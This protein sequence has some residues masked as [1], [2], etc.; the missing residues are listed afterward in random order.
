MLCKLATF[1]AITGATLAVAGSAAWGATP[2]RDAGDASAA[3]A[4]LGSKQAAN[5]PVIVVRDSGDASAAKAALTSKQAANVVVSVVRDAGDATAAKERLN[6][7]V[8]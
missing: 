5:A 7:R 6:Y 8:R 2:I 3:R 4:L 1:G